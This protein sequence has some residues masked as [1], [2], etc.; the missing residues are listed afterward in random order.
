MV[1]HIV[2]WKLKD[3]AEGNTKLENSKIIKERLESLVGVIPGLIEAEVGINTNG[4]EYDASLICKFDD[5]DALKSYDIHPKHQEVRDFI[6]K[7]RLSRVAV[8]YEI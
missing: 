6:T 7:I 2:F 1:K 4:G 5:M 3:E 8:D